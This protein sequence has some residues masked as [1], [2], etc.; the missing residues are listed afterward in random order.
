M[1]SFQKLINFLNRL[2][3]AGIP[4][5]LEHNQDET[6]MVLTSIDS[7]RWEV[8]FYANGEIDIEVFYSNVEDA[9]LEGEE[10]LE[11]LFEIS[12]EDDD[13]YEETEDDDYEGTEDDKDGSVP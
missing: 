11:R 4:Y 5:T 1:N 12:D 13:D 6:I 9:E 8:E 10:A 7:E 2:D 3:D